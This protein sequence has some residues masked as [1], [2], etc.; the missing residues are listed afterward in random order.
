MMK[1][2]S[3]NGSAKPHW[4][5][6]NL[7]YESVQS[8][9]FAELARDHH[10]QGCILK[11]DTL[12]EWIAM[13][14][15]FD[16]LFDEQPLVSSSFL[17]EKATAQL[18]S[19]LATQFMPS[20]EKHSGD[21][22][23][24]IPLL[25]CVFADRSAMQVRMEAYVSQFPQANVLAQ[26]PALPENLECAD[27]LLRLGKSI[28]FTDVML[29]DQVEK[30]INLYIAGMAA[31]LE[32]GQ[33]VS[34]I[35]VTFSAPLC[36]DD[37]LPTEQAVSADFSSVE[38]GFIQRL[39]AIVQ[40]SQNSEAM[41]A[42]LAKGAN[43][44]RLI[45]TDIYAA[46]GAL[47]ESWYVDHLPAG[48][49]FDA[50]LF[51]SVR[52]AN[53]MNPARGSALA[54]QASPFG[55]VEAVER[56]ESFYNRRRK[57]IEDTLARANRLIREK[58]GRLQAGKNHFSVLNEEKLNLS[59]GLDAIQKEDLIARIWQHDHTVWHPAPDEI[60]N[61]LGWL[62]APQR[63]LQ[64]V[65]ILESFVAEIILEN[66]YTHVVLCGMGG[67]S[68]APEVFQKTFGV[69]PGYLELMVLD[70]TDPWSL[71]HVDDTIKLEN[72]L[73]LISTKSGSTI[74]TVSMMKYFYHRLVSKVG[75][76]KAGEQF[77][78][79][80]DPGSSLIK[81]AERYH[82][83]KV[84]LND[85]NIGGRYSA[86]SYFG[87]LPA[88]LM[89]V[90][91]QGLLENARGMHSHLTRFPGDEAHGG[92]LLGAMMGYG[93]LMGRDKLTFILS[94]AL[95]SFGSWVEQLIAESTGK[96]GKGILPVVGEKLL[97]PR[98]YRDDRLFVYL[99]LS[100]DHTY[101]ENIQQLSKAGFPMIDLECTSIMELGSQFLLWEFATV[102]AG[103]ILGIHPFDQP[104]VEN[105]KIMARKMVADYKQSGSL[106]TRLPSFQQG[107]ISIFGDYAGKTLSEILVGFL[108]QV[109]ADGYCALQAYLPPSEDVFSALTDI[110]TRI[111]ANK[112]CAVTV[113][114]GPRYLHST[115]QLH[116]GDRG[117]GV[118][119]SLTS[120]AVIDL[121]IPDEM[122]GPDAGI[123]F[124]ILKLAAA[125]GD[126]EVLRA[127]GRPVLHIHLGKDVY[128]G[129]KQLSL[130][131]AKK[132]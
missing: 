128:S 120:D 51:Q 6:N 83:R 122:E 17:L 105:A 64:N 131:L 65:K 55:K 66:R 12:A 94:P 15:A 19:Y 21:G 114:F 92:A 119:I 87:L 84:F 7:N 35:F 1:K 86:L 132:D 58:A 73:F 75:A 79:I 50:D 33:D 71:Y 56:I 27:A 8:K 5:I 24:S 54:D 38:L 34:R 57:L 106:S 82:F 18:G 101:D 96:D 77:I 25:P 67:S 89:G 2:Q 3:E 14:S 74:E 53:A 32:N 108:E 112:N 104:D 59:S 126:Q 109:Q 117:N 40:E 26:I 91:V 113:G 115:G 85:P 88:A 80:T 110:Q 116:K 46:D 111:H 29:A 16:A 60:T 124:G 9:V 13:T 118:F 70:S 97:S 76:T 23:V 125:L 62:H 90:N 69:K 95:E 42:V 37:L 36:R 63:M 10:V 102:T 49:M 99:H 41:Q 121:M 43:P 31:R 30:I 48:S 81:I 93:A 47:A 107:D 44:V 123:S 45:W 98:F 4:W 127:A 28:H 78:A 20:Y 100:G 22:L 52:I 130:S 103:A 72:T 11:V 39:L 61:R 68:L 129:L